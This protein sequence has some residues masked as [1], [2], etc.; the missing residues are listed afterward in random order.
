MG[1]G[2]RIAAS[3]RMMVKRAWPARSSRQATELRMARGRRPGGEHLKESS[4]G[5]LQAL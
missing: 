2:F 5:P 1:F 3:G 4:D